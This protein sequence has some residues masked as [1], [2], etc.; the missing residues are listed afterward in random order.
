MA[1]TGTAETTRRDFLYIAT[2]AMGAVGAAA[3]VWPFVSQLQPDASVLA[4]SS[5]EV[6]LSL[7]EEG[8]IV[9]V[10]WRGK[11]VFVWN[12]TAE[13]VT[14][15]K[16]V[17]VASLIDPVARNANLAADAPATDANRAAEGDGREKWLVVVGICTHLGCVPIGHAGEFDGW[18]CPCHGSE[19]DSAGRVRRGP[20]P[21]NL[22]VP[23]YQFVSD[24]KI[25]IG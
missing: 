5:T 1:T 19:Y 17:P 2:G 22:A 3:L 11:P 18:F 13:D 9:T 16:D 7:I 15:A 4:L 23:P 8:Q 10:K 6:D 21:E 24:T 25:S 14:K 12:R 20:A